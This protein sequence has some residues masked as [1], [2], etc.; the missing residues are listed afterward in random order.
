MKQKTK[1]RLFSASVTAFTA[2]VFA[3]AAYTG[4]LL[5]SV[6][7][8]IDRLPNDFTIT[9]HTGAN[10]TEMNTLNSLS[11][12]LESSADIAEID[13]NFT[14][15]GTPV[16]SHNT[17]EDG[18]PLLT[19]AFK[20]VSENATKKINVDV[21][22]TA[23]LE[24]VPE[25]AERTGISDRIFFTGIELKDIDAVR[26]KAPGLMYYL[27]FKPDRTRLDEKDYLLELV[28]T[29][30]DAGAVGLNINLKY[31]SDKLVRVFHENGLLVSVWTANSITDM[32]RVLKTAP[33]NIT[34]KRPD[35][36]SAVIDFLK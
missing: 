21:K 8:G 32:L 23:F 19:D 3:A 4:K 13:L 20:I 29:V 1:K 12:S 22:T 26:T 10:K 7:D 27:N 28:K 5:S 36:L 34:T 35:V 9:A 24:K 6:R 31:S 25:I 30:K 2:C 18:C 15:D 16:L 14:R 33:D 17:P 11:V